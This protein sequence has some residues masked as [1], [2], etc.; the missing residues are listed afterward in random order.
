MKLT[1]LLT[2]I[3]ASCI[4]ITTVEAR[5]SKINMRSAMDDYHTTF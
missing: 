5:F 2:L 3:I 1:A 4:S